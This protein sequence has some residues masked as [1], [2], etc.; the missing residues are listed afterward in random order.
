M[1]KNKN[2]VLDLIIFLVAGVI[3]SSV[4]TIIVTQIAGFGLTIEPDALIVGL[5]FYTLPSI[6]ISSIVFI[7]AYSKN[8]M[9]IKVFSYL[10]MYSIA[11]AISLSSS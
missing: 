5:P 3:L 4:V 8:F 9:Q 7:V 11:Y 2:I 6:V 1:T 10:L